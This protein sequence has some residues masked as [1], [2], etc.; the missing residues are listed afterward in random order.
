V[1]DQVDVVRKAHHE[2]P[3]IWPEGL[4]RDSTRELAA[5]LGD[6]LIDGR[7]PESPIAERIRE[8]RFPASPLIP[9][10]I[11]ELLDASR[12]VARG[13][14]SSGTWT[15]ALRGRP[16]QVRSVS[17]RWSWT[18]RPPSVCG[19]AL[20]VSELSTG[21]PPRGALL[22]IAILQ[23][24]TANRSKTGAAERA[25]ERMLKWFPGGKLAELTVSGGGL[26]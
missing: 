3:A 17:M 4:D 2:R 24:S 9:V 8:G 16:I 5:P 21:S 6:P 23:A 12:R 18:A 19:L 26:S 13:A 1:A 25:E 14:G 10:R 11:L 22:P 7:D 15:V 20:A